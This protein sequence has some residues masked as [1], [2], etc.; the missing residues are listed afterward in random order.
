MI[1]FMNVTD[2]LFLLFTFWHITLLYRDGVRFCEDFLSEE[3]IFI[4]L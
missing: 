2:R 1:C 3:H 4:F